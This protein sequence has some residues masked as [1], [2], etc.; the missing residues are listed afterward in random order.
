MGFLCWLRTSFLAQGW[1]GSCFRWYVELGESRRGQG[2]GKGSNELFQSTSTWSWRRA[3]GAGWHL[4]PG[5]SVCQERNTDERS[6]TRAVCFYSK[7]VSP[8]PAHGCLGEE[9]FHFSL[10]IVHDMLCPST[11]PSDG[12]FTSYTVT[13]R[14]VLEIVQFG[15]GREH[16]RGRGDP[17]SFS[18]RMNKWL[19]PVCLTFKCIS[20]YAFDRSRPV[21][22]EVAKTV[23]CPDDCMIS[24]DRSRFSTFAF[25]VYV[26]P[27][28]IQ[29]PC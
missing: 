17:K 24:V 27:K 8:S 10:V 14:S 21:C 25:E 5:L 4:V 6:L 22:T 19:C 26:Q 29:P 11:R 3:R 15:L 7:I 28:S 1:A 20:N 13:C 2:G 18:G 12:R 23:D 9:F 16:G